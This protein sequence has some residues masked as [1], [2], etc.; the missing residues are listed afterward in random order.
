[1]GR[2]ARLGCFAGGLLFGFAGAAQSPQPA[3][4]PDHPVQFN[5]GLVE[6]DAV[7]TD[8]HGNHI[9][10]L[11]PDE[12]DVL[13][14]GKPQKITH[15]QFVPAPGTH[16]TAAATSAAPMATALAQPVSHRTFAVF[17]DDAHTSFGDWVA[18]RR[19]LLK[20]VD[21]DLQDG[22]LWAFYKTSGGSGAWQTFSSDRREIRSAVEHMRWLRPANIGFA[23]EFYQLFFETQITRAIASLGELPGR[24]IM[25]LLN[26]GV[27]AGNFPGSAIGSMLPTIQKVSDAANRAS[28]AIEAIDL[29]G[30]PVGDAM[31]DNY[32]DASH[33]HARENPLLAGASVIQ[34]P[35]QPFGS[36]LA[37]PQNY[38]MSQ[39]VAQNISQ[40]TGGLFLHDR[41]DL[42]SEFKTAE[43]DDAGYYLIGW[44]PGPKAFSGKHFNN[45]S[46]KIHRH[47]LTVRSRSGFFPWAGSAAQPVPYS[48]EQ[49]MQAAIFSPFQSGDIKVELGAGFQ[50]DD[51]D[52][53]FIESQVHVAPEGI[54]FEEK[55]PGCYVANLEILM[56]PR[57]LSEA[58]D[59]GHLTS[60]MT[61]IEACG[62]TAQTLLREGFVYKVRSKIDHPGP[63]EMRI[64]VRNTVQG[65]QTSVGAKT[66]IARSGVT[67]AVV[68]IGS[69]TEF[70]EVPDLRKN[71]FA[72]SGIKL[73]TEGASIPKAIHTGTEGHTFEMAY[74]APV[75]GDPAV[76]QFHA[77]ETIAYESTLFVRD[78]VRPTAEL[79]V[80]S[81]STPVHSEPAAFRG[82]DIAGTYHIDPETPPG[83]YFLGITPE[84]EPGTKHG[85]AATQWID[86]E[87]VK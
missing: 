82:P 15:F 28:V 22:D 13:Q 83:R 71:E 37:R 7:V 6:V 3:A 24:K 58:N 18:M 59:S 9:D 5:V 46:V 25:I 47:G 40:E 19:S 33:E 80:L 14:D 50:H 16:G 17:I 48:A 32:A 10:G 53:S 11:T 52:G 60:Q 68:K 77:G 27:Y 29:R 44:D 62:A 66:L 31:P 8:S 84:D 21:E 75:A 35:V 69:A 65:D 86:F 45:L 70:V 42:L 36:F 1:M 49:Q 76:R 64:A 87:V 20:F 41:N 73:K 39:S 67:P 54:R 2:L 38:L 34:T 51:R 63:Y 55:S 56:M 4:V 12:F 61:T 85:R 74:R 43:N 30:L 72:L 79:Q 81:E 57:L 78:N 23:P 26:S